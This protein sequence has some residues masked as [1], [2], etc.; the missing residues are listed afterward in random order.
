L[1]EQ[2]TIIGGPQRFPE[3]I[4]ERLR[5]SGC[6]VD[7]IAGDGTSIATQLSER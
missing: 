5:E 1:A 3:S 2:V 6:I 4:L 7:R